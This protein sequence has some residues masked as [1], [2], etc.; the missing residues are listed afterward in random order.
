MN[1]N[2]L[3]VDETKEDGAVGQ[4]QNPL[5]QP[6]EAAKIAVMEEVLTV[7]KRTTVSGRVRVTKQTETQ[8]VE[9]EEYL[10]NEHIQV[11]RIA[12]DQYV[13]QPPVTRYEGDVL[14]I[15]VVKEVLVKRLLL[16]EELH[17]RRTTEEHPVRLS[18]TLRQEKVTVERTD[19]PLP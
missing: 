6:S 3:H 14:V 13:D 1:N 10:Q 5:E 16:V 2:I 7:G 4:S 11:D 12:L 17:V 19:E 8:D 15:P 18:E 9:V